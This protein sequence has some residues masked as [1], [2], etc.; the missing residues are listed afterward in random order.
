MDTLEQVGFIDFTDQDGADVSCLV[1][2]LG[3]LRR[4]LE[5]TVIQRS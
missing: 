3:Q 2:I 4:C 1:I 5:W